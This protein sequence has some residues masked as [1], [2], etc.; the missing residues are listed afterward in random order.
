M[1]KTL[2]LASLAAAAAVAGCAN[3]SGNTAV[4]CSAVTATDSQPSP[5]WQGTVFTIVME[6]KSQSDILGNKDA[7]FINSLAAQNA[8]AAGYRDNLVH[9]SEPNYL[10]MIA[11]ENFGVLDDNDPSSHHIDSTSHIAD[12][13]DAAGLSWKAYAEGMGQPCDVNSH[14]LYAAKH[15][16]LVFFDDLNGWDGKQ[17]NPTQRCMDRVVD[18]SQ[19]SADVASGTLPKY[20]FIAPNMI[21]DMHDGTVA[22][23]DKWLANVLPP[24]LSSDAFNKGGVIFLMWDEGGGYPQSDNPPMIVISPHAKPGYVST[25]PYDT[26]SYLKTVQTVLGVQSLPCDAS[27]D[28]VQTMSDL[29]D[30]PLTPVPSSSPAATAAVDGGAGGGGA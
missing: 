30:V 9:P 4:T 26:S 25:V 7:P 20:V 16:P 15:N 6:N 21:D 12:Q 13:L 27:A 17:F 8:I 5:E 2:T 29:F 14:D 1:R 24:I 22:D 19:L 23:G 3:T 18:F 28:S 11:G 10:W